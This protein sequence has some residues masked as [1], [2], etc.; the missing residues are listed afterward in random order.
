M[1]KERQRNPLLNLIRN[2]SEK[3]KSE[4]NGGQANLSAVF[5]VGAAFL[6]FLLKGYIP[7]CMH[8]ACTSCF[9]RM[10]TEQIPFWKIQGN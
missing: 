8:I 9:E 4:S 10:F 5:A 7:I 6:S 2:E 3:M 1:A